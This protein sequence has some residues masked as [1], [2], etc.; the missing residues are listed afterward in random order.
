MKKLIFVI[1]G[2]LALTAMASTSL[3]AEEAKPNVGYDKGFY[4]KTD[5]DQFK[6]TLN[7][8]FQPY[9][10]YNT[11]TGQS[12]IAQFLI[13]RAILGFKANVAEVVSLGFKLE[14][15]TPD[16]TVQNASTEFSG[17]NV[18]G[19]KVA[20]TIIP[21]FV[22]AVGMTGLPLDLISDF[23]SSWY[24]LTEPPITNTQIDGQ[25]TLTPLR[26]S[27]G[28]P[29]GLGINFSGGHWKWYYS[30]SVVD[31]NESNYAMGTNRTF[32]YGLKT[33]FNVLGDKV[34]TGLTDFA[35][36]DTPM[37]T[38]N[39]GTDYQARRTDKNT[40]SNIRY[41]WT[42]TLGTALRW[43][44]FALTTEGYYRKTRITA[45]GTAVWVRPRLTDVGYY[46]AAGYYIIPKKF[47]IA[48]QAG[49]I[50]R[51]GP[52]NDSW[53]FGGGLN[54]YVFDNNLKM[55]LTYVRTVDFDDIAGT[56]NKGINTITLGANA[57]F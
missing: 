44:G 24:L 49:Q 36:S 7:G 20:V 39:A 11:A 12:P 1:T 56:Q 6:L 15:K 50:F 26:A 21:E 10:K 52:D 57:Y 46:A 9:F 5:D 23:D 32:S 34:P 14:H 55:Q 8:R 29:Q 4:I 51:Q 37:L 31:G 40:G 19:A 3:H 17:V 28:T 53:Q 54:W 38:V 41:I 42:S 35:C 22:I 43:G 48:A 2:F 47:E 30:A 25:K 13:R 18:T 27:F 16:M 33:G 45:I